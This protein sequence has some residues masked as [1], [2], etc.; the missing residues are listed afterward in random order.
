MTF[1]TTLTVAV[2]T[3]DAEGRL[4]GTLLGMRAS[5][6]PHDPHDAL[7]E[8]FRPLE[9]W[10]QQMSHDEIFAAVAARKRTSETPWEQLS[11]F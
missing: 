8:I 6:E 2:D 7:D 5:A 10:W 9:S 4:T 3:Y 1:R 11:I